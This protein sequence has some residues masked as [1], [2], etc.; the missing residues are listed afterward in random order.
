MNTNSTPVG[1]DVHLAP[2]AQSARSTLFFSGRNGINQVTNS[3]VLLSGGGASQHGDGVFY[4]DQF[5][6]LTTSPFEILR[7]R[8]SLES[9]G[10]GVF[11]GF[12]SNSF[13]TAGT[14]SVILGGNGHTAPGSNAV[15]AGGE[16]NCAAGNL[17]FAGGYRAEV[18]A[19]DPGAFVWAHQVIDAPFAS[20]APDSFAVRSTGGVRFVTGV[21]G[22]GVPTTG[23]R[24]GPN[25]GAWSSLSD[26]ALKSAIEAIDV[27]EVLDRLLQVPI[28]GWSYTGGG[29]VHHVGPMAQDFFAA[30]G[31]GDSERH[32][33]TVDADG[34]A[35]AAIQGL[36]AKVERADAERDAALAALRDENA[37]LR[38]E[39]AEL[40]AI[41][42][43]LAADR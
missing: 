28:S 6:L 39:L 24:I 15:V 17:S 21:G 16:R 35:L 26:R 42:R 4:V 31:L 3:A 9:N 19:Q 20:T 12:G 34:I 29:S 22:G 43:A 13:G 40:R 37:T 30:F 27:G 10:S 18:R 38:S 8:M 14:N 5:A 41:V 2:R 32:I 23:V 36:N 11:G 33:S 25:E 7:R 1:V